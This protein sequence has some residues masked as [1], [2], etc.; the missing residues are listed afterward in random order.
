MT[1]E[2]HGHIASHAHEGRG[3]R[4]EVE[5]RVTPEADTPHSSVNVHTGS[6]F[7]HWLFFTGE[8]FCMSVLAGREEPV[9]CT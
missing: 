2:I 8:T 9:K 6:F 1:S 4:G 5:E 7:G 3:V